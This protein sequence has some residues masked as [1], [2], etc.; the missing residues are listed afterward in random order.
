MTHTSHAFGGGS[1]TELKLDLVEKY[2]RAFNVA[3]QRVPN[4]SRP[5]RRLYVDA[6]AG[7][8]FRTTAADGLALFEKDD[9]TPKLLEGSALRALRV[10]PGFDELIFI[11][12]S[13][14]RLASLEDAVTRTGTDKSRTK[15][16]RGNANDTI[17]ELIA[18]GKFGSEARTVMFLDPYGMQVD[19][20]T[21]QA[22][23]R[24]ETVDLWYLCP[25]GVAINRLLKNNGVVP[26]DWAQALE[27]SLGTMEWQS[28]FMSPSSQADL[29]GGP[30][31]VRKDGGIEAVERYFMD[32]LRTLFPAVADRAFRLGPHGKAPLYSLVFTSSNPSARARN[33]SLR[34]ANS[35]LQSRG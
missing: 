8:G 23:R 22:I 19:W 26:D 30:A 14:S 25:T 3:L 29:F 18:S 13:R 34:I 27:R 9:A 16:I 33:L 6:F 28:A 15:F 5:F 7:S 35:I 12:R 21:L 20:R 1:W 11:E 31:S 32:R 2:L 24:T 10:Q 4:P 17:C